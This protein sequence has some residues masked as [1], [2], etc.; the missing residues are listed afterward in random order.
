M[1]HAGVLSIIG[2]ISDCDQAPEEGALDASKRCRIWAAGLVKVLDGISLKV[3][4][5]ISVNW[6][7][8]NESW[9]YR[10]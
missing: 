6:K 1:E 3:Y 5:S 2:G 10:C 4:R 8:A 7:I 9:A